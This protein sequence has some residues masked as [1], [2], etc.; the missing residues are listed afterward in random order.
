VHQSL[1]NPVLIMGMERD[2]AVWLG[3]AVAVL[4]VCWRWYTIVLAVAVGIGGWWA[5]G[6]LA[7]YD[8]QFIRIFGR[9]LRYDLIYDPETALGVSNSSPLIV[10]SRADAGP[11]RPAVPTPGQI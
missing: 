6:S 11:N 5:L 1:V 4:L 2:P 9:Y 7:T 3:L 8:P 10:N